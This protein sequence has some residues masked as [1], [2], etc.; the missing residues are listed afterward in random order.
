[1]KGRK[2]T[3]GKFLEYLMIV[4]VIVNI[5]IALTSSNLT[6]KDAASEDKEFSENCDSSCH[7]ERMKML[8]PEED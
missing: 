3:F 8:L 2:L 5:G 6:N 1:M 4:L 7:Q